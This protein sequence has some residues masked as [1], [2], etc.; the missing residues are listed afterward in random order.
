MTYW[1]EYEY[2]YTLENGDVCEDSDGRR[3]HCR[4]KDIKQEVENA[5]KDE[6]YELA[7]KLKEEIDSRHQ[8]S[9]INVENTKDKE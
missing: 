4:K 3:F 1:V 8:K 2:T 9:T 5:V 6:N 7:M